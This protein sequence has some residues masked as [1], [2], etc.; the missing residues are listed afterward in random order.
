VPIVTRPRRFSVIPY[1][2]LALNRPIN[3]T[4]L[5]PLDWVTYHRLAM[6]AM[7]ELKTGSGLA[8]DKH[9]ETDLE[10]VYN[11]QRH[12]LYVAYARARDFLLVTARIRLRVP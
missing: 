11:T 8:W 1:R 5:C 6:V 2:T 12:L 4:P 10:Y 7:V 9:H 3:M